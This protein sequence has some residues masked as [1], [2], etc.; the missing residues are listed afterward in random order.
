M[1]ICSCAAR[2]FGARCAT[3]AAL[4]LTIAVPLA[5]SSPVHAQR[6]AAPQMQRSPATAPQIRATEGQRGP[7]SS[8]SLR[9]E[10]RTALEPH[11]RWQQHKRWGDVWI[12]ANRPRDWR[13][14]TVG[15]WVYTNDWGWYW[16]SDD[17]EASW[18]WV[19]YHYGRWAYDDDLGWCWIPGDEWGPA[20]V[21][22]RRSRADVEYVGW[23]PLPPDDLIGDYVDQP[24]FWMFVRD[25][26]FIAPRLASVLLPVAR[27]DAFFRDTVVV[28]R[29]LL[30][31]DRARFA[32]NPGISPTYIAAATH[33]PLRAYNIRPAVVA[34]TAPIPGARQVRAQDLQGRNFR[35]NVAMQPTQNPVRAANRVQPAQPLAPGERGRLS[36]QPPRA[37]QRGSQSPSTSGQAERPG[38]QAQPQQQLSNQRQQ[39]QRRTPSERS[40]ERQQQ[41]APQQ[42]QAKERSQRAAQPQ[43]PVTE[44]RGAPGSQQQMRGERR[45]IAPQQRPQVERSQRPTTEGRGAVERRANPSSDRRAISPGPQRATPQ[46]ERQPARREPTTQGRGGGAPH[47]ASSPRI[48]GGATDGR[49][50]GRVGGGMGG[51]I[52]HAPGGGGAPVGHGPG[53]IR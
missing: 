35:P 9:S 45:A 23:S 29:T 32:V 22:W 36:E 52:Q 12:P 11:G 6:H 44:G 16:A 53:G 33:Q 2:V 1:T 8:A 17:S 48:Q 41:A 24:R 42:T 4:V 20:W 34:G 18:G 46:A 38:P 21:Q 5:A 27:Y 25:R 19:A 30:A 47:A 3:V 28:N 49:G 37:A 7:A 50:G 39:G 15:R 40:Q 10:F 51:A 26:D 14:Y 43:R 31:N 13:P